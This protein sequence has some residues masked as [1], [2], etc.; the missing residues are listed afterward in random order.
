M[1]AFVRIDADRN[2]AAATRELEEATIRGH[3]S[4]KAEV[5]GA[6]LQELLRV[7][8]EGR[9]GWQMGAPRVPPAR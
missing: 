7:A 8:S 2:N 4:F 6:A 5:D 9:R 1:L 3:A